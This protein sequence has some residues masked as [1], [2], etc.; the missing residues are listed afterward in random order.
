M[1]GDVETG[2]I[3]DFFGLFSATKIIML[4]VGVLI[5]GFGASFVASIGSHLSKRFP[6]HR[7]LIAQV[8]TVVSFFVY[9]AG[10][11]YLVYGVVNP[12]K[13]LL[14][15]VSG[16]LAVALG[17]SLKDLVAS[18]VAGVILLFDKPFQVGDRITFAGM[19]GEVKTIGLRTV[20]IV[21]L[22]DSL[23][24][25]PN[26]RFI[27]EAVSS[28]NSGALDMMIETDFHI[29]TE[30]D[31][32]KARKILYETAVSSRYTFMKKTVSIVAREVVFSN[33]ISIVLRIKCYVLDVRFEK[34]LQTDL[35]F[36]GNHALEAAGI[37]R[38][39]FA[40]EA[41]VV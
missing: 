32:P 7:L 13:G 39:K 16:T 23:I 21:T 24:T 22:D 25:I 41:G 40:M 35:I 5:L 6:G 37:H 31:L 18:V 34:A 11:S 20:R 15:A 14:L 9:I 27:T 1:A 3:Q 38:P 29:S 2:Q 28:G 26:N 36:R 17:L 33:G 12:P 10:G 8:V 19:Y 4:L 30:S